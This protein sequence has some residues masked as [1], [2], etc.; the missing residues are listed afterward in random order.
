[1]D[2]TW[3][4][5]GTSETC[6][7]APRSHAAQE[8]QLAY[9]SAQ[10]DRW[11]ADP[12]SRRVLLD[13]YESLHG[14][15]ALLARRLRGMELQR[16]V[17]TG[18]LQAFERGDL[19]L[20]REPRVGVI[21][22]LTMPVRPRSA[23]VEEPPPSKKEDAPTTGKT[24]IE[25]EL[26]D[27]DG[28][29]VPDLRYQIE[30]PGGTRRS[31]KLDENGRAHL[32]DLDPGQCQVSFPDLDAGEW[33]GPGTS[34]LVSPEPQP[35]IQPQ[36]QPGAPSDQTWV[37]IGLIDQDG[38]AVPNVRYQIDL[39]DGTSKTGQLD[40]DGKIRI[41]DLDPGT[42]ELSFPDIDGNEYD[43]AR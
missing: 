17:K 28:N 42:Y 36:Q 29:A 38:K 8:E 6:L 24:W 20:M 10:L 12:M 9:L 39:A 32:K 15:S 19:V 27:Q 40:A 2:K 14:E 43:V 26:V 25:V 21:P 3:R 11:L 35:R 31:G 33:D 4:L 18:L 34:Q 30:L 5:R 16:Y 37:D 22:T 23:R 41:C 7:I 13:M 1:M